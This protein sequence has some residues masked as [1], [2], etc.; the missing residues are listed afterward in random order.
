MRLDFEPAV[1]GRPASV[2]GLSLIRLRDSLVFILAIALGVSYGRVC[3][4]REK[5]FTRCLALDS[6]SSCT[7]PSAVEEC[8]PLIGVFPVRD[9]QVPDSGVWT[10]AG[11]N[12]TLAG[13]A[14]KAETEPLQRNV[15]GR[16]HRQEM[17]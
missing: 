5:D 12:R 13:A 6:V 17:G 7:I 8:K 4:A 2:T 1:S 15:G 16:G 14:D 9:T 10:V 3:L 11:V